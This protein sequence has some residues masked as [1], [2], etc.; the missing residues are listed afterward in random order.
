ML[1]DIAYA[2][3]GDVLVAHLQGEAVVLNMDDKRYYRLNDTA[4]CIWKALERQERLTGI[5]ASLCDEFDV[6]PE[7]AAWHAERLVADL[8]ARGLL[9]A[10]EQRVH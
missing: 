8:L 2:V 9:R 4:A 5:V 1:R 7:E 6:S 10:P 3:P